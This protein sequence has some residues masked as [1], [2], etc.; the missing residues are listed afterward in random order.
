MSKCV[1]IEIFKSG[2]QVASN[3]AEFNF[4]VSDLKQAVNSFNPEYFRPPTIVSHDTKGIKDSEVAHSELC[5]GVPKYLKVVGDTLKAGYEKISPKVKQWVR[6]GL[7]HSVS[8]S[9]YLPSSPSNPYPGKLSLRHIALLGKTPPAVKGLR[10][11]EFQVSEH[12]E[13][14][15]EFSMNVSAWGTCADLFQRFREYLIDKESIEVADR[16][17]PIYEI[18]NLRNMGESYTSLYG[19]I[20]GLEM[21]VSEMRQHMLSK[22]SVEYMEGDYK[23]K[24]KASG[25]SIADI[26]EESGIEESEISD[27]VNNGKKPTASQRKKLDKCFEEKEGMDYEEYLNEREEAVEKKEKELE[28]REITDFVESLINQGKIIA[29]KRDDTVTLL[30]A[31]SD[32]K[33]ANFSEASGGKKTPRQA[34]KDMLNDQPSWN[35]GEEIASPIPKIPKV[36]SF[37]APDGYGVDEASGGLYKKAVAYAKANNLDINDTAEFTEALEAVQNNG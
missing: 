7:L 33:T 32:N 17:L 35:Y 2:K 5:Y 20:S 6:D 23:T 26:S 13:G 25:K 18:E 28:K 15:V 3:G 36:P 21:Q 14:V 19:T 31:S 4:S 8:S 29:A 12:Q 1:E 22:P 37:N 9:F 30:L 24:M 27:I 34:L 11:L 10:Q 16:V